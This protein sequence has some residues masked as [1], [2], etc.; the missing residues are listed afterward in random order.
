MPTFLEA[1]YCFFKDDETAA[2]EKYD[3]SIKAASEHRFIHEE[4]LA[5]ALAA[6]FHI[7]YRRKQEALEHFHK[8]KSCYERWGACALVSRIEK[9]IEHLNGHL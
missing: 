8:A 6:R 9:D 3:A 2:C 4:G 5:N 1:E 7:H